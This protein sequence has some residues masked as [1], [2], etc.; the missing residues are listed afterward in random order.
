[1]VLK[2]EVSKGSRELFFVLRFKAYLEY[3]CVAGKFI[4]AQERRINSRH[5]NLW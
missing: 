3:S 2:L 5:K 1:M 4:D